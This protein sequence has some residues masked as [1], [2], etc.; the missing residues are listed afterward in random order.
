MKRFYL[1]IIGF[2]IINI[3]AMAQSS[4]EKAKIV[5]LCLDLPEIQDLFPKDAEGNFVAVHIMQ[6]PIALQTD[7]D[8][9]KFGIS[10]LFMNR[11]QIYDNQVDTYF[12]FQNLDLSQ[13]YSFAKF[14]LY[15]H[16]TSLEKKLWMVDLDIEK[17]NNK[18]VVVNTEIEKQ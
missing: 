10:P 16:Q 6:Y 11:E 4:G 5:Q 18:W 3:S 15:H 1:T 17:H 12:L 13:T 8:V 14:I 7:I 9:S 2:L